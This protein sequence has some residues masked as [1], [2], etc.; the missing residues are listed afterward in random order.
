[1]ICTLKVSACKK[2]IANT[3]ANLQKSSSKP[4]HSKYLKKLI[5]RMLKICLKAA[6][7]TDGHVNSI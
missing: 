5:N 3:L 6:K 2:G 4:K 1:M 7:E